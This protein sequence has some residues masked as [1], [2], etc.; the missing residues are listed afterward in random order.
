M[1]KGELVA[2]LSG[3]DDD[4]Q[5]I[6]FPFDG[7]RAANALQVVQVQRREYAD[8][9]EFLPSVCLKAIQLR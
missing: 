1:T 6:I 3:I 2:L 8:G 7:P 5:L 9:I 4:A